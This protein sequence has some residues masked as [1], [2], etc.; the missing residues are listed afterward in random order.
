M[1]DKGIETWISVCSN[2]ICYKNEIKS[3]RSIVLMQ[4]SN[5]L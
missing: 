4:E 3:L 5:I 1:Q 2:A